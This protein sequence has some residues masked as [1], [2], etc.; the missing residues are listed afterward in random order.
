MHVLLVDDHPLYRQALGSHLGALADVVRVIEVS[1]CAQALAQIKPEQEI[2]LIL[3]DIEL[4]DENGLDQINW[5][6][7]RFPAAPIVVISA[8]EHPAQVRTAIGR[9]AAGY[10]PKSANGQVIGAALQIVM[11][12]GTYVP[13]LALASNATQPISELTA[14]QL[15]ILAS[16]TKGYS[17]KRIANELGVAEAT[18]RAH[19]TQILKTLGV[20][21]R[22]EAGYAATQ[23]GL[24]KPTGG[25]VGP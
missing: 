2:D 20:G 14:R 19:V 11:N 25:R 6:R 9:G 13:A 4:A 1:S 5:L 21:N 15:Q 24:L 17:N 23:R 10:I 8:D 18:V 3:L 16:L 7:K 22:T 12:G